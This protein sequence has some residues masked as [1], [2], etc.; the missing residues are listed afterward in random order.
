MHTWSTSQSGVPHDRPALLSHGY[1]STT[2]DRCAPRPG[3]VDALLNQVDG[4]AMPKKAAKRR[5][6]KRTDE[7]KIRQISRAMKEAI[8]GVI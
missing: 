4:V 5:T 1:D 7:D 8:G 3:E 6:R 2:L